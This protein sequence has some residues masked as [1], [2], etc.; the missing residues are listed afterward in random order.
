V[1]LTAEWVTRVPDRLIAIRGRPERIRVDRGPEFISALLVASSETNGIE[2]ELVQSGK[3]AQNVFIVRINGGSRDGV[4]D[5]W[6]L[7]VLEQVRQE[8]EA[9]PTKAISCAPK[10]R[11]GT[12]PRWR[13]STT[14][15]TLESLVMA[16]IT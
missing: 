3:P 12:S 15:V 14:V 2:F 4:L 9:G 16:G 6:I 10:N 13:L 7:T 8:S 1:S 11:S 5:A